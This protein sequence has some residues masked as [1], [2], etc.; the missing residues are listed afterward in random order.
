MRQ[1]YIILNIFVEL[2]SVDLVNINLWP[3][4][5]APSEHI[6]RIL[7]PYQSLITQ[8]WVGPKTNSNAARQRAEHLNHMTYICHV[9]L[10]LHWQSKESL[11]PKKK[12]IL[13]HKKS[14]GVMTLITLLAPTEG[15]CIYYYFYFYSFLA[16]LFGPHT[17]ERLIYGGQ[18][19]WAAIWVGLSGTSRLK[20]QRN[21]N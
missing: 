3:I 16:A 10:T 12:L 9:P 8:L 2:K 7:M 5:H 14:C 1:I 20:K 13:S 19:L 11:R 15:V 17:L 6:P 18:D 4:C 21:R